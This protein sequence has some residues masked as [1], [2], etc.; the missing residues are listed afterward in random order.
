VEDLPHY[1]FTGRISTMNKYKVSLQME[2]RE[3][4]EDI[5]RKVTDQSQAVTYALILLNCDEGEFNE[6]HSAGTNV[7]TILRIRMRKI[8]R[9]KNVLSRRGW[10]RIC[11]PSP[12]P[13]AKTADPSRRPG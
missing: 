5:T 3:D 6:P 7:V 13:R 4:L 1:F 10:R 11:F 12:C 9:V 8:D 2:E